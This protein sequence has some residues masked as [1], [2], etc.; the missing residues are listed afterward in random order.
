M[1]DLN[2]EQSKAFS[3]GGFP[4]VFLQNGCLSA[5]TASPCDDESIQAGRV[6]ALLGSLLGFSSPFDDRTVMSAIKASSI[7]LLPKRPKDT[8]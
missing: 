6:G 4:S 3:D 7:V 2:T 5:I 8:S 1:I